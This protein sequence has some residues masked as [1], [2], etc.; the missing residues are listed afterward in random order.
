MQSSEQKLYKNS[1]NKHILDE[2]P[3]TCHYILDIGCG[4]GDNAKILSRY[5]RIV[6]GI[7]ISAKEAEAAGEYCR[8]VKVFDVEEGLPEGL[9]NTYDAIICSH[10]LEHICYPQKL[11]NDIKGKMTSSN[12]ILIISVP[13]LM[14]YRHR[15]QLLCGRFEYTEAGVM[16]YTHFRWYTFESLKRL[17][18]SNGFTIVKTKIGGEIPCH[19]VLGLLPHWLTNIAK[20]ILFFVSPGLFGHEIVYV[21]KIT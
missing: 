15:V 1:G 4:A 20:N 18:E 6:D 10:L 11:F 5:G 8:T 13:N 9:S 3:A 7:T 17:V 2:V 16:D 19:S 21:A 12:S 14:H